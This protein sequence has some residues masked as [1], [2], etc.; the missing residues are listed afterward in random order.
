[1]SP[2][3]Q[4]VSLKTT[5]DWEKCKTLK[6]IITELDVEWTK[7]GQIKSTYD[8]LEYWRLNVCNDWRLNA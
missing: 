4:E 2:H 1:M 6:E 5:S 3:T 7:L 8:K